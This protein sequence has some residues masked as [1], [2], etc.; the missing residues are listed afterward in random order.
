[1]SEAVNMKS[2]E[3]PASVV[4]Y[5][6]EVTELLRNTKNELKCICNSINC[7]VPPTN[8]PCDDVAEPNSLMES[9]KANKELA[10]QVRDMV[11]TINMMLFNVG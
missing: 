10:T 6:K 2:C 7:S 11:A 9:A 3:R 5:E 1:M 8:A 4:D